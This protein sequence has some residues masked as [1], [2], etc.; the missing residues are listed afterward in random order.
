ML[1]ICID[2]IRTGI[3]LVSSHAV[4]L[5]CVVAMEMV[6]WLQDNVDDIEFRRQAI[7]FAQVSN[8]YIFYAS[9]SL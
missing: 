7:R 3:E 9:I 8:C 4:G 5:Q 2:H 1:V 6:T